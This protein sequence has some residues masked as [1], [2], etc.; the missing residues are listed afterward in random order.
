MTIK[1]RNI[2]VTDG[3][4]SFTHGDDEVQILNA[5]TAFAKASNVE[6]FATTDHPLRLG[7]IVQHTYCGPC[8][9]QSVTMPG[10]GCTPVTFIAKPCTLL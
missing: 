1:L 9:V 5:A 6:L 3:A 10:W 7:Q 2:L 8:V 4:L